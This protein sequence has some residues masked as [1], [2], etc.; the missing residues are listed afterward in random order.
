MTNATMTTNT[1]AIEKINVV[2]MSNDNVRVGFMLW[3]IRAS[4]A[5]SELSAG[6]LAIYTAEYIARGLNK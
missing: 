2:A 4:Q 3:S 5:Y 1:L 6:M